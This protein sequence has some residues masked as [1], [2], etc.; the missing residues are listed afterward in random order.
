[1]NNRPKIRAAK[2]TIY[3]LFMLALYI[4]QTTPGFLS[5]FGIKPNLVLPVAMAVAVCEGEFPGG[6][7]GAVAGILCDFSAVSLFG[8]QGAILLA[9]CT[10]AGLLTVYWLRPTIINFILLLAAA[11]FIHGMLIYL[12]SFYMWGYEDVIL[13]LTR[14]ILPS[15]A[16]T[17]LLSPFPFL[18][19]HRLHSRFE[20]WLEE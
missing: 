17:L 9:C 4:L 18:V 11:L 2:Y 12:L 3:C 5:V 7:F 1:M 6:I 13:V 20:E 8:F 15:I 16:Y 14:R 10:A 19:I